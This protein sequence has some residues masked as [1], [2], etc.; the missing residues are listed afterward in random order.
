MTFLPAAKHACS[1]REQ[2]GSILARA[3]AAEGRVAVRLPIY[4]FRHT[5]NCHRQESMRSRQT[6]AFA[7]PCASQQMQRRREKRA[8]DRQWWPGACSRAAQMGE[9]E[10]ARAHTDTVSVINSSSSREER[11][12]RSSRLCS[13]VERRDCTLS[14]IGTCLLLSDQTSRWWH[15]TFWG[16][17][18]TL[19]C[20]K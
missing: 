13:Q 18:I 17:P 5:L 15:V 16:G 3:G 8:E 10:Y 14:K 6:L 2:A 4:R 19:R 9:G 1:A 12:S 20:W 11:A 7:S